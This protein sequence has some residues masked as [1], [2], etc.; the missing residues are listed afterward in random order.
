M[1]MNVVGNARAGDATEVPAEVVALR[2]EYLGKGADALI[3]EAVNLQGLFVGELR[4]LSEMTHGSNEQMSG[5]IG[6][7]VQEDERVPSS[8]H[9]EALVV[10]AL[11]GEA[12]DAALLLVGAADVLEPPRSPERMGHESACIRTRPPVEQVAFP[13]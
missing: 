7:L 9:D 1:E 11:V 10:V 13:T 12:E 4:E 3:G 5:R 8:V 2:L 6:E